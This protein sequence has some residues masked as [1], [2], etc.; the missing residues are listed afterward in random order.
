MRL[1]SS[2]SLLRLSVLCVSAVQ[3]LLLL[4]QFQRMAFDQALGFGDEVS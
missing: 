1:L 4:L 2:N 3:L